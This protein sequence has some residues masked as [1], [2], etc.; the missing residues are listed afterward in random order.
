M[1][2]LCCSFDCVAF[3]KV[4]KGFAQRM[5]AVQTA[6]R[7]R[8]SRVDDYMF[9]N[10]TKL[11]TFWVQQ[12]P[13]TSQ[14]GQTYPQE[15]PTVTLTG[16]TQLM[17]YYTLH[18]LANEH[19]SDKSHGCVSSLNSCSSRFSRSAAHRAAPTVLLK[20]K[21]QLAIGTDVMKAATTPNWAYASL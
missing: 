6:K 2:Q 10:T 9:L 18:T 11:P 15:T 4:R 17:M 12:H 21:A 3:S 16:F 1:P 5:A 19:S 13:N 14:T 7:A 20:T 8:T